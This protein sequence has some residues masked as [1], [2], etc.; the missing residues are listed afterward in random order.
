MK[1]EE[2]PTVS[3]KLKVFCSALTKPPACI[4]HPTSRAFDQYADLNIILPSHGFVGRFLLR[5]GTFII[6]TLQGINQ[7]AL[8]GLVSGGWNSKYH[9]RVESCLWHSFY[10]NKLENKLLITG[11][12]LGNYQELQKE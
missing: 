3:S 9:P 12:F 2:K 10:W 1:A 6:T 7:R 11:G 4:R 5:S 8:L